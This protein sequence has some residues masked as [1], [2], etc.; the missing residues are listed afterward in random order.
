MCSVGGL[1]V[2]KN[3]CKSQMVAAV[4]T[5]T[6]GCVPKVL[7]SSPVGD[8][9]NDRNNI[10]TTIKFFTYIWI[11]YFGKV[12]VSQQTNQGKWIASKRRTLAIV[13]LSPGMP[14]IAKRQLETVYLS[15]T[16][17][18]NNYWN[19]HLQVKGTHVEG[20]EL[21]YV[22]TVSDELIVPDSG[23]L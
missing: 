23:I 4:N 2:E 13:S 11:Q 21:W 9:C 1:T 18:L 6:F 20:V 3:V 19:F 8:V 17:Q 16:K 14:V 5:I 12:S 15:C 7:I 22:L 10:S